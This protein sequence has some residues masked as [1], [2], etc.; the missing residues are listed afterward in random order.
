MR[1]NC[2]KQVLFCSGG[3][4]EPRPRRRLHGHRGL[5]YEEAAR[6]REP[7]QQEISDPAGVP[8]RQ[9]DPQDRRHPVAGR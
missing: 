9:D 3:G 1:A 4:E 6:D 2:Q 8:A 7:A 5:R